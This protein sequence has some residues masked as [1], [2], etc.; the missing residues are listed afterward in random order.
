[1]GLAAAAVLCLPLA[2]GH[3]GPVTLKSGGGGERR[4]RHRREPERKNCRHPVPH[5]TQSSRDDVAKREARRPN[6]K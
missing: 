4:G 1:M 3:L 5:R 6:V 2:A